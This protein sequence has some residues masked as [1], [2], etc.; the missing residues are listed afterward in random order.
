LIP[1]L[2]LALV[3]QPPRLT[4]DVRR[5]GR[6]VSGASVRVDS[7]SHQSD[8]RGV[9][10]FE[11]ASG[12]HTVSVAAI[13]FLPETL[14]VIMGARDTTVRVD[15]AHPL[16]E[17]EAIT[18]EATR[19]T[20]RIEEEPARVEVLAGADVAEKTEMRPADLTMLLSEMVGVRTQV[21]AP[22][23]GSAVVRIQ[24][25]RGHYTLFLT[26][27]LPL[28]GAQSGGLSLLQVPPLDLKQ[29]EVIKGAA[30]ALY[31]P[32][33]LG[34]VVNLVSQR[35][36]AKREV[37]LNQSSTGGSDAF[38]WLSQGLGPRWGIT[39]I[40]DGHYQDERDRTGDGW[41][42]L[43]GFTRAQVRPRVFWTG[44]NGGT[45]MVTGS[46]MAEDRTGGTIGL[47]QAPDGQPFVESVRTRRGDLG[48]IAQ[49]PLG[50]RSDSPLLNVRLA[51]SRDRQNREFGVIPELSEQ[52]ILFGETSLGYSH[53]GIDWVG[54]LSWERETFHSPQVATLD[55]TF[56]TPAV[57][58][59]VTGTP[60]NA[61]TATLSARCDAHN[62][63]GTYCSPRLSTLSKFGA[64]WTLRLSAGGGIFVP[65]PF[66]EETE[67]I[68]LSALQPLNGLRVERARNASA[69][70]TATFGPLEVSSTVYGSRI[71]RAIMLQPVPG[72]TTGRVELV[73]STG[74]TD[75]FG[76]EAFAV[77]DR[78]P[79][80][81]TA[82]YSYVR[83]SEIDP[84]TGA[85]R[86]V[87][88]NPRDNLFLD[89]AY[90]NLAHGTW[91]AL[92]VDWS[93]TQALD[94][95]PY[96]LESPPYVVAGALAS[97]QLGKVKLFL[98][99][100]NITDVRQT[101]YDPIVLPA[102]GPGGRW[103]TDQWAPLAG[104]SVNGGVRVQF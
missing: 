5:Q 32:E 27:G 88:L 29:V 100:Q 28:H 97:Q 20:R 14:S 11:L 6:P 54:G 1:L 65:T 53:A 9:A 73:N 85:R 59:Q 104:R 87:P 8:D 51:G 56:T 74:S 12:A 91:V 44:D 81:V 41:A 55:Y 39:V 15:L 99:V 96:R 80:V 47:A 26:D 40:G 35:P 103:T 76:A 4:V 25:L 58:A 95:D 86:D 43:P 2:L 77:Y 10:L 71:E 79:F 63:Y 16:V 17:L 64:Q 60:W 101:N 67:P 22:T 52:T 42:D 90:E 75:A 18:V 34:G 68:A 21:T 50:L 84:T 7:L 98:S 78:A 19:T 37:V 70:L 57:F 61:L 89:L 13:G 30:S 69:D 31:G 66:T 33:A 82:H 23:V 49:V 24:G 102:R 62:V 72:D 45:L 92:E 38:L 36:T 3:Q 48:L 83:S 46:Y 93:G 94:N